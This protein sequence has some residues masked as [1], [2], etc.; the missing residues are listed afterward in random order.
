MTDANLDPSLMKNVTWFMLPPMEEFYYKAK[1]PSY[2]SPPPFK[3][4]SG[5]ED[6]LNPM[7][8]IYPRQQAQLYIPVDLDG[9]KGK[10]IFKATHRDLNATVYWSI[11][12]EVLSSTKTYHNIEIAPNVGKHKL[13]LV[14]EK[15]NRLEQL[16]EVKSK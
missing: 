4:G 9:K 8:L 13:T 7:Q 2:V 15:G 1:N 6:R 11:D 10:A 12:G 5:N 3:V 16:F 14:D